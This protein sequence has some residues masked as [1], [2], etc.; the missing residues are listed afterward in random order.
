MTFEMC[1][2]KLLWIP[3]HCMHIKIP[4]F[5]LAHR[6]PLQDYEPQLD[7]NKSLIIETISGTNLS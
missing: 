7:S 6:G 2:P 5:T 4:R 3:E 1:T